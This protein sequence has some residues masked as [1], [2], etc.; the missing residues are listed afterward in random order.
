MSEVKWLEDVL[1]NQHSYSSQ[2]LAEISA[3]EELFISSQTIPK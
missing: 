2:T 3:I 1:A